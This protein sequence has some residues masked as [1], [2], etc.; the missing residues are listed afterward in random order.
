MTPEEIE[1]RE[2]VPSDVAAI[3]SMYPQAFPDEDLLPIVGELLQDPGIAMSLVG[4]ID[5]QIVGH[6]IFTLCGV[7]GS[8]VKAA[9]L[10]PL[11]V[12]PDWQRRGIGSAIVRAGIERLA[13]REVT[14]V[15]VL[16]DPVYY[17]RFGFRPGV[18]NML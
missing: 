12:S 9:L 16:G 6:G 18:A 13:E 8:D 1:I 14:L 11:A 10:G 3:N 4:T 15:F 5:S 7:E 2:S 17:R